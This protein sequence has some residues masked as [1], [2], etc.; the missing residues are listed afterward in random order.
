MPLLDPP[1]WSCVS[2]PCVSY[3]GLTVSTGEP[4]G[5]FGP[6][7]SPFRPRSCGDRS[8]KAERA[9]CR[10]RPEPRCQRQEPGAGHRPCRRDPARA[11]GAAGGPEPRSDR[12]A[13]RARALDRAAH[14]RSARRR[15]AADRGLADRPGPPRPDHPA[16]RGL[17]AHRLRRARAAVPAQALERAE[18]DRRSRDHQEGSPHLR[19]SGDRAA[20]A[21]RGVGGR[22]DLSALLHGERQGL[23]R[24]VSTRWRSRG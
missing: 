4:E 11:R 18:R 12:A 2:L 13:R 9:A 24:G 1:P 14:R 21:A 22:R 5:K 16:A 8:A 15:E 19:R 10:Q 20:A 17:G 7:P 3:Y 6:E 23:S